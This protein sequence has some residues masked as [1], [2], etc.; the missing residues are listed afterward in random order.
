MHTSVLPYTGSREPSVN[1][2]KLLILFFA[3]LSKM[4]PFTVWQW[5]Y[6]MQLAE[7]RKGGDPLWAERVALV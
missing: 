7:L 1:Q 3:L 5:R 6:D 2:T 4:E